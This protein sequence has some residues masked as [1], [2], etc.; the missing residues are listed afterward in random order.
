MTVM[1]RPV[2]GLG[3]AGDAART[4]G[5]SAG[6]GVCAGPAGRAL[7]PAAGLPH[8]SRDELLAAARR[9]LGE[10]EYTTRVGERYAL[11]HLAALRAAAAVLADRARPRPGRRGRPVSAWCLLVRVAPELTEWADFFAAGAGRRAA[12]EAGLNV[13]GRRDADDLIRQVELFIG[14]VEDALGLPS[15]PVLAGSGPAEGGPV[16]APPGRG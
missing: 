14:A 6:P 13:V 7:L 16:A 1:G 5:T 2:R 3:P 11:A 4:Q 9:G 12:A 8:R 10:A 15:Q